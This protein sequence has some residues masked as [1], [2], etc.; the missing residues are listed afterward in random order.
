MVRPSLAIRC[1]PQKA[2]WSEKMEWK[3]ILWMW[4]FWKFPCLWLWFWQRFWTKNC[5]SSPPRLFIIRPGLS[6]QSAVL[7][8]F[9]VTCL[10]LVGHLSN[11]NGVQCDVAR[12]FAAPLLQL[13]DVTWCILAHW[14]E[15]RSDWQDML[16]E[17]KVELWVNF[18][19]ECSFQYCEAATRTSEKKVQCWHTVPWSPCLSLGS[20]DATTIL[21]A[22]GLNTWS[23]FES[24]NRKYQ[25]KVTSII[26]ISSFWTWNL[27]K[28][29][30][31]REAHWPSRPLWYQYDAGPAFLSNP[32][33]CLQDQRM[34]ST[35]VVRSCGDFQCPK[36]G[37]LGLP[38][39]LEL[40]EP[41][42]LIKG[43]D[44]STKV[45]WVLQTR[46]QQKETLRR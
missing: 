16:G 34:A 27:R 35:A 9:H 30:L 21:T 40:H 17:E 28:D 36:L 19:N 31:L 10:G 29:V 14:T 22:F 12:W 25:P 42:D 33:A 44:P 8:P 5:S 38:D 32:G 1:F 11:D 18:L 37:G 26:Q 15:K 39:R 20:I 3:W 13:L 7:E 23:A 4:T 2:K 43:M 41:K 45:T 6:N 46:K 24:E